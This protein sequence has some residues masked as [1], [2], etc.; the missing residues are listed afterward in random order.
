MDAGYHVLG[1]PMKTL[2][3]LILLVPLCLSFPLSAQEPSSA[4]DP[5]EPNIVDRPHAQDW[6]NDIDRNWLTHEGDDP[7]WSTP[8]LDDSEWQPVRLDDLG[9]A[10]PGWRWFRRHIRLHQD[11]PELSLLIQGGVGTYALY[12]NGT[13]VPGP[14]VLSSFQVNR[15]VERVFTIT[16]GS[17][18]LVIA[19]RTHIPSGYAAWRF[20][21]FMSVSIGTPDAIETER[22]A[23]YHERTSYA[24]PA[25]V[26]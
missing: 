24:I 10:Q 16:E 2:P 21:Q 17:T 4:P 12:L 8:S 25:L 11:H 20:P 15:P 26:I 22:K 6:I 13:P 18:D 1:V 14:E 19:L 3:L 23:M 9:S 5:D 7:I